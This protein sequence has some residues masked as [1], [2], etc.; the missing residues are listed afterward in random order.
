[1]RARSR[2][3]RLGGMSLTHAPTAF[4]HRHDGGE[5]IWHLDFLATI[6]ASGDE[7]GGRLT[8]V[9][10]YG[11]HGAGSPLH[12]HRREDEWFY[13]IEGELAIWVGGETV[14]ATA[15]SFAY[16][17]RDIPHTF[18]ITSSYARFLVGAE[19]SG[20]DAFVR[21]TGTPAPARTLP[22]DSA[23]R[24]SPEELTA[25]AAE[26]GIEILGPPGIPS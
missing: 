14:R 10:M 26:R 12:V 13:V 11:P 20:F 24:P 7:T 4:A 21:A 6:L 22:P 16:A 1:M 9:E 2:A 15:G 8:V 17:P 18:A 3:R 5:A 25:L 23:S 19:P